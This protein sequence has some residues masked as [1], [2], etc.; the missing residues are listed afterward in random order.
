MI[1]R[2]ALPATQLKLTPRQVLEDGVPKEG[3]L[4]P[5]MDEAT[6]PKVSCRKLK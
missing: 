6:R 5:S 2:G 4:F 1:S 3:P